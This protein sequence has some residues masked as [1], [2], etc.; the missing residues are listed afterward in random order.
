M[1][2]KEVNLLEYG[3]SYCSLVGA[4]IWENNF[5]ILLDLDSGETCDDGNTINA[6]GC[7]ST[8]SGT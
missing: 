8:C 3:F 7:N 6:D 5:F 2:Q 1:S 4:R